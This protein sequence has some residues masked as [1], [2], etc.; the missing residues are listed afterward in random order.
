[1]KP[2]PTVLVVDDNKQVCRFIGQLLIDLPAEA[3]LA[4]SKQ[5]AL[6]ILASDAP[7]SCLL[8]DLKLPDGTGLELISEANRLR[9]DL[10]TLLMSGYDL[11]GSGV[12]SIVKPFEPSNLLERIRSLLLE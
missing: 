12:S 11:A 7:I 3:L 4:Y 2:R 5:E 1:V 9:P 10:P 6:T 8:T